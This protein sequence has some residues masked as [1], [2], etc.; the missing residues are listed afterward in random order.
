MSKIIWKHRQCR[1]KGKMYILLEHTVWMEYFAFFHLQEEQKEDS[2][3]FIK[4]RLFK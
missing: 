2:G 3:H 4:E 1:E